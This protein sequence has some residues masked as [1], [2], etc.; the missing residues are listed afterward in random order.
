[1]ACVN[2]IVAIDPPNPLLEQLAT[3]NTT[4]T[5]SSKGSISSVFTIEPAAVFTCQVVQAGPAIELLKDSMCTR[6]TEKQPVTVEWVKR[7]MYCSEI[8]RRVMYIYLR[9]PE[10]AAM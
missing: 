2:G 9:S 1:M 7:I 3:T 4:G 8:V 10:T 5:T 6:V